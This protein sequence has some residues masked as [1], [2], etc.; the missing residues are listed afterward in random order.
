MLNK[1]NISIIG[2][3]PA[4]MMLACCLDS[5]KYNISIYEKNTAL[6]RK[7]LVAGSGGFNLTHSENNTEFITRY[8]PSNFIA[9]YL[10]KFTNTDL[11]N[12]LQTIGIKT[13]VGSSKR[14]FPINGI[15]PIEVLNAIEN[16]LKKND[17][18][19]FYNYEWIGFN[20]ADELVFNLKS[21]TLSIKPDITIFALGGAS[22]KVTGSNNLWASYFDKKNISTVPFQASNCAFKVNWDSAFIKNNEGVA[23]KNCEFRCGNT[24]KK[25]EAIITQFGIEGSGVYALS[26][27]IRKELNDEATLNNAIIYID[28]KPNLC[29]TEIKNKL[30]NKG[31]LSIKEV[32]IK[33]INLTETQINLIKSVT[34]KTDYQNIEIISK[35]IKQFSVN[36]NGLAPINEAISTVGGIDLLELT[37]N[38]ELKKMPNYFCVGEMLNWDAPTGGYLLQA[39]FSMGNYVANYL[40]NK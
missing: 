6:G 20:D 39:C 14:V 22:W 35:L 32:L 28:F 1:K 19:V 7:F 16:E 34:T 38:L 4:A 21:K 11:I 18:T 27:N 36:V 2:G 31:N 25:G 30:I 26:N 33:K 24:S 15:K 5:K 12:W 37:P 3:G 9:S 8:T 10:N 23:L 17:T 29:L 13:Y 40:N